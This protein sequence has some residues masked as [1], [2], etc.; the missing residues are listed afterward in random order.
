[1]FFT[2]KK[3]VAMKYHSHKAVPVFLISLFGI[4]VLCVLAYTPSSS[5][6]S[7]APAQRHS[8]PPLG[9]SASWP[10]DEPNVTGG[11]YL[12]MSPPTPMACSRIAFDSTRDGNYE[13][14]V[15]N[16]DGTS[17]TRLTNN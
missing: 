13:I 6:R 9:V 15:M 3:G 5:Y 16:A 12:P 1:M 7:Y 11:I 17:Q 2:T 10:L 8:Q 14:Y 4:M